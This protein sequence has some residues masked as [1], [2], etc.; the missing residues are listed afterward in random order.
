MQ[1]KPH[2]GLNPLEF[3]SMPRLSI[4]STMYLQNVVFQQ[5]LQL[6]Y[7]KV[8]N[9]IRKILFAVFGFLNF[10]TLL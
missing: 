7:P 2:K 4:V 9:Q 5:G 1:D 10:S 6:T 8:P 3:C